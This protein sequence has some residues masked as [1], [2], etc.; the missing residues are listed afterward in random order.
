MRI[1]ILS[2]LILGFSFQGFCQM[3]K[4]N[5]IEKVIHTLFDGMRK[6][7]STMLKSV[8]HPDAQMSSS[9][10]DKEGLPAVRKGS[11]NMFIQRAGVPHETVWDERISDLSVQIEDNLAVAWMQ[12]AFYL[13]DQFSH[14]G[15][16]IMNLVNTPE[17]WKIYY[18]IDTRKTQDC[19][20]YGE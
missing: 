2:F 8:F 5:E 11:A 7:D 12:Y 13:G 9:F 18:L 10:T 6:G 4:S 14:C 17:G 1:F 19:E 15:V 20:G 3:E 16:N